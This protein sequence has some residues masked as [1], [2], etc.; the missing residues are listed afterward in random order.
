MLCFLA[1]CQEEAV[2]AMNLLAFVRKQRIPSSESRLLIKIPLTFKVIPQFPRDQLCPLFSTAMT[3]WAE[4]CG[5]STLNLDL[6]E[7]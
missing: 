2:F 7:K 4:L 3:G 5:Q 1:E 6:L